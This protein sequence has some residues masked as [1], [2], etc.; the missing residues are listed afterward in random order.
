[1]RKGERGTK[2]YFVKQLE[3]REGARDDELSTRLVPM[4]REYTVFNVDQC[5][6]LRSSCPSPFLAST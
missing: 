3:I 4:L 2:I 6:G 5:D 1:V